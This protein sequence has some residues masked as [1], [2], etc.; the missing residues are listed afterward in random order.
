MPI[1]IDPDHPT[2]VVWIASYPGSGARRLSCAVYA[3]VRTTPADDIDSGEVDRLFRS[4]T[5]A[6]LYEKYLSRQP[7]EV[8]PDEIAAA[9]PM[10]HYD[11]AHRA[12]GLVFV[13]TH[14]ARLSYR[15]APLISQEVS[16]G[17]IYLVRNPMDLVVAR[18]R[19]FSVSIEQAIG[20]I[21]TLDRATEATPHDVNAIEGSWS[22]NV[23]SWILPP[24]PAVLVVRFEDLVLRPDAAY[25]SIA[26]HLRKVPNPEQLRR[27][28]EFG[29]RASGVEAAAVAGSPPRSAEDAGIGAW[30]Q[31]FS[32]AQVRQIVA[33]HGPYMARFGY[34]PT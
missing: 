3:L 32:L 10:V 14:N 34:L 9:R 21:C 1:A 24:S 20:E 29:L 13:R 12:G 27:A 26:G 30:R 8:D 31:A 23:A 19:H 6:K 7:H 2:G 22:Q 15:D 18:A 16:V 11:I 5:S 4:D 17:A 25:R 28:V 33:D